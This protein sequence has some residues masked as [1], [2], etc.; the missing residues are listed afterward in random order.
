MW[1]RCGVVVSRCRIA[2][3]SLLVGARRPL[4][5]AVSR[6]VVGG[7]RWLSVIRVCRLLVPVGCQRLSFVSCLWL[8]AVGGYRRSA[9]SGCPRLSAV[10]DCRASLSFAAV[11]ARRRYGGGCVGGCQRLVLWVGLRLGLSVGL[12]EEASD[13]SAAVGSRRRL[14]ASIGCGLAVDWLRL[15]VGFCWFPSVSVVVGSGRCRFPS[16]RRRLPSTSVAAVVDCRRC[17]WSSFVVGVC[18]FLSVG[19]CRRSR[20][21]RPCRGCRRCR[22]YRRCRDC[23]RCRRLPRLPSAAV[24]CNRRFCVNKDVKNGWAHGVVVSHLLS[25]REALSSILSV[26]ISSTGKSM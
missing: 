6:S 17:R 7:R 15:A 4:S 25:M 23:R 21:C 12:S 19:V 13:A 14:S 10:G 5:V 9:V 16:S 20:G 22:G 18:R 2:V 11:A 26:S 24:G 8:L 1:D 3:E